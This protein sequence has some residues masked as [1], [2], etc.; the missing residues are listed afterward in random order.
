LTQEPDSL[1]RARDIPQHVP[2]A[3]QPKA[4]PPPQAKQPP[5]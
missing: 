2:L 1:A 5:G 3:L 4:S